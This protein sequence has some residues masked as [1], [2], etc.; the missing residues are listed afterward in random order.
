MFYLDS[1]RLV[2]E[3]NTIQSVKNTKKKESEKT[4]RRARFLKKILPQQK[5]LLDKRTKHW[6]GKNCCEIAEIEGLQVNSVI[7]YCNKYGINFKRIKRTRSPDW[8][9]LEDRRKRW[10]GKSIREIAEMDG[11]HPVSV[12]YYRN[13]HQ[14]ETRHEKNTLNSKLIADRRKRWTGK[15]LQEIADSEG[16]KVKS[17]GAYCWKYGI[18]FMRKVRRPDFAKLA[19]RRKRWSGL[20]IREIEIGRAHV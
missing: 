5:A 18:N 1:M 8:A 9:K 15:T 11:M 14:I 6:E 16:L 12:I 20:S 19:D 7:A 2:L 3:S 13:K 4:A 17:V 10:V